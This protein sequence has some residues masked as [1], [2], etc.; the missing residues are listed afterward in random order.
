[1][2]VMSH[3]SIRKKLQA[4]LLVLYLPSFGIVIFSGISQRQSKI[5][6]ARND[7][8]IVANSLAA[9]QEQ[10]ASST[11]TMLMLLA[12]LPE[13][14]HADAAKCNQ[15][16]S[17][18]QRRFPYYTV[19]LA[20]TPDGNAFASSM[21]IKPGT[22]NLADRKHVKDAIRT[23]D[24]SVGEY[25]V[26]R[27]SN[28]RSLN[29]TYPAFDDRGNLAAIVIA[30]FNLDEFARFLSKIR[31]G[32]GAAVA[33]TDWKGVRLFRTPVTSA[34]AEGVPIV[35]EVFRLISGPVR[36]GIYQRVAQDGV[37]RIYA[38]SQLRLKENDPPY[39]YVLVGVAEKP[40]ERSANLLMIKELAILGVTLLLAAAATW[41]YADLT[42]IRPMNRLV[43]A[44]KQF[45]AGGCAVRI[46]KPYASDELGQLA[47][48]FDE[49]MELLEIR[50][51]E[52]VTAE[53]ALQRAHSETEFFL[54]CIPSILIGL[55][56]KG[57]ITRW[58]SAAEA[59]FGIDAASAVGRRLDQCGVQWIK[60]DLREELPRWLATSSFLAQSCTIRQQ[61][62]VR[63]LELGIQPIRG[64]EGTSG[65]ILTGKD[66]THRLFLEEQLH[67]A[68][69]LEA[70]GQL[71]AGIAHEINTPLQYSGDNVRFLKEAWPN[72]FGLLQLSRR[73]VDEWDTGEV[74]SQT[75]SDFHATW[76]RAD[77][78]YLLCETSGAIDQAMEGMSR[79]SKIV[80][81][82]REFSH[83][84]GKDKTLADINHLIETTITVARNEWKYVADVTTQ[85][86]QHL[87]PVACYASE[88]DQVL[89][90]LIVNA[91]HAIANN[92]ARAPQEKGSIVISTMQLPDAVKIAI[93][94]TGH[95]IPAE[96]RSRVFEP[97]FTTKPLGKG[98]GQGLALAHTVVVQ[99]HH[100][101]IWFDSETGKGTT[102]Y[103]Q[104]PL[105]VSHDQSSPSG[106]ESGQD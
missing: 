62:A 81:A 7:A 80:Q 97:F 27:I 21:P 83:P 93:H 9:Q 75:A 20:V 85:F 28:V 23:R 96:I 69:K 100:G 26:G 52:R 63:Y 106:A 89:L 16:F 59:T 42:L 104:L 25:I 95:G 13:V 91:A 30:G 17:D 76:Q 47:Y 74:Q 58:N 36:Q 72:I 32:E 73:V 38:Y 37:D 4:L 33:I 41:V 8:R 92:P 101:K 1:M 12:Q 6:E 55:D 57:Y 71:A 102:F 3:W 45:G 18:I 46:G 34:T 105:T 49:A 78:D 22:V 53:K 19:V 15:I 82:M 39:M 10:I 64:P 98:T 103:V 68:Q 44:T 88:L 31:L 87:S 56:D 48:S 50:D 2:L 79:I 40:I 54:A 65:L 14:R 5:E 24:F 61:E 70:V 60:P 29:Y 35:G 66:I 94:D 67:Q 77:V 51:A 11:K 90:N 86:D 99:R 43:R 84:R